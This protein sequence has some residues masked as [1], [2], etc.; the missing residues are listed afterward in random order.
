MPIGAIDGEADSRIAF[1]W[2]ATVL[3][4]YMRIGPRSGWTFA[5]GVHYDT[6]YLADGTLLQFGLDARIGYNVWTGD[7]R[8]LIVEFGLQ[9]PLIDGL[10]TSQQLIAQEEDMPESWYKPTASLGFQLTF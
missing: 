3:A 7:E 6:T 4:R 2:G 9:A 8:F 1:N 5:G 10:S